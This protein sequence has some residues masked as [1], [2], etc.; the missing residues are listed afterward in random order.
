MATYEKIKKELSLMSSST[1]STINTLIP[2]LAA[3]LSRIVSVSA[4]S[5]IEYIRTLQ[6][7]GNLGS[8]INIAR[9]IRKESGLKGFYRGWGATIMRDSPYS[10]V[11]W[12][13]FEKFRTLLEPKLDLERRP[14][15]PIQ[16]NVSTNFVCGALSG[17][18][19]ASFTHPMDVIKTKHQLLAVNEKKLSLVDSIR[20]TIK[21]SGFLSLYKGL[22]LRL[23]IV[24]PS[25]TIMV[26]IYEAAKH[27]N[28]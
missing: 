26:T 3:G 2:G 25:G 18:L 15:E 8:T 22:G 11:Y 6:S 5:P 16:Y 4:I 23:A 13:C 28:F 20:N 17:A 9:E 24:I 27:L 14:G 10:M 7:G 1:D 19:A 12:L 21:S